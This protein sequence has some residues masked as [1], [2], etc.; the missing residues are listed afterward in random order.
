M[1]FN[2]I[3]ETGVWRNALAKADL[4]VNASEFIGAIAKW[5]L[6]IVFL[7]A[8]IEILGMVQ[9]ASFLTNVVSWLPNVIIA[10]AIFV[11][12]VILS[13]YLGKI[14]RA[15]VEGT[16]VGYGSFVE[17]IVRWSIW[18]FAILAILIQLGI[19]RQ[20]ILTLFTGIVAFLAIGGGLAFGLGGKDVAGEILRDLQR[21]TKRD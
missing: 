13:D 10:A 18:T 4:K 15:I 5:I 7:L 16:E 1:R 9:F 12:A 6:V 14:V 17:G 3:F 2:K 11:V 21:R 8:S 19:A 20:L